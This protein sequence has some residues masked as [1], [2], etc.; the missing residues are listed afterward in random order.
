MFLRLSPILFTMISDTLMTSPAHGR[1][2]A[3]LP[4][5]FAGPESQN[6][7]P[8]DLRA[9][10]ADQWLQHLGDPVAIPAPLEHFLRSADLLT[11]CAL[12]MA[13]FALERHYGL[14]LPWRL[15]TDRGDYDD[16]GNR[17]FTGFYLHRFS[18]TKA[19]SN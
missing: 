5:E 11:D 8:L 19:G 10:P 6:A 1:V 18:P 17:S 12:D 14:A 4:S 2:P 3:Y 16:E 9:V 7:Y 15:M 13:E